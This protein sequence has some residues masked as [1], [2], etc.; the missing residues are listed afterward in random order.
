ME[1]KF[2][3]IRVIVVRRSPIGRSWRGAGNKAVNGRGKMR[4]AAREVTVGEE[5]GSE[6]GCHG[7]GKAS[8]ESGR[9]SVEKGWVEIVAKSGEGE[10]V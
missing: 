3:Q 8:G 4:G 1:E 9:S 2:R 7:K 5:L 6:S 10:R